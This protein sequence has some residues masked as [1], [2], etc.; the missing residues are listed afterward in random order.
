M[1][2]MN[3][4]PGGWKTSLVGCVNGVRRKVFLRMVHYSSDVQNVLKEIFMK[5]AMQ[6]FSGNP[7]HFHTMFSLF[8]TVAEVGQPCF[9]Y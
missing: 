4:G 6:G 1:I 2:I 7:Y 5:V 8:F 3:A 9:I